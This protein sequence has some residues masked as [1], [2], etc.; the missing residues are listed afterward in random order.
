[1]TDIQTR[2]TETLAGLPEQVKLVAVSKFHPAEAIKEAYDAGQRDF[3]ESRVQELVAKYEALPQD[4]KWHFIGHLQLNKVKYIAPFVYLIHAVDS[5]R[6]L[7]EINK[8]AR[9]CD[10][11]LPCLLQLHVAREETKFG[12]TTDE[13]HD[14]LAQG[15]WRDL[16]NVKIMGI[17]CM[18][19]N[20]DDRERVRA[21]FHAAYTFYKQ[22]K[23]EFFANEPAFGL[24]SCGMS[25]DYHLAIEEGSTMVRIGTHIF[26]E[27]QY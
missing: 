3:G 19:S 22:A 11:V 17:M 24:R 18:A 12:F 10:R 4:I 23:A 20:T 16:N 6:L 21:D 2:L 9:R 26:G 27:R 5:L 15:E 25:H 7:T 13:L 14:M 8:Q 1:M